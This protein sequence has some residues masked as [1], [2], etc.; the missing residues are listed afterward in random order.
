MKNEAVS[1]SV[2]CVH[3]LHLSCHF[4]SRN[5]FPSI[6]L[7]TIINH[8]QNQSI[9]NRRKILHVQIANFAYKLLRLETKKISRVIYITNRV[10]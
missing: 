6:A 8:P 3:N 4:S 9:A 2:N 7:K 10:L 5:F 1:C